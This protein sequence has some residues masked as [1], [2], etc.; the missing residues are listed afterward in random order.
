MSL[1]IHLLVASVVAFGVHQLFKR[2]REELTSPI[3]DFPGPPGSSLLFGNTL[4]IFG[5]VQSVY[6]P[7]MQVKLTKGIN[8]RNNGP[9]EGSGS[10]NM[11]VL[12]NLKGC[13]GCVFVCSWIDCTRTKQMALPEPAGWSVYDRFEGY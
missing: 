13:Y 9:W 1:R 2:I 11:D 10:R 3:R 5:P 7:V 8:I 4:Q 12:C 6:V